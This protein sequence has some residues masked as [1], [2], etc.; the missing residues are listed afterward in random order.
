MGSFDVEAF[1]G[2]NG[3]GTDFGVGREPSEPSLTCG[4]RLS[5]DGNF[6]NF[7]DGR[8]LGAFDGGALGICLWPSVA[9]SDTSWGGSE[10]LTVDED[11]EEVMDS[12]TAASP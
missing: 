4:S 11:D 12:R 5:A 10:P 1:G 3:N 7:F 2:A 6:C 9:D 8:R